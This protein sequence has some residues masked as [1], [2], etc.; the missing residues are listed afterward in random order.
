M[1]RL[2]GVIDSVAD[3]LRCKTFLETAMDV[4]IERFGPSLIRLLSVGFGSVVKAVVARP[5]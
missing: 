5:L 3:A 2:K 4:W 1:G